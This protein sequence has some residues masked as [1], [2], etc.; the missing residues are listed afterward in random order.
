MF[1]KATA[2][3]RYQSKTDEILQVRRIDLYHNH[4]TSKS[5]IKGKEKKTTKNEIQ[6]QTQKQRQRQKQK[7]KHKQEIGLKRKKQR[8]EQ[9]KQRKVISTTKKFR[10]S[11]TKL[12]DKFEFDTKD[13]NSNTQKQLNLMQYAVFIYVHFVCDNAKFRIQFSDPSIVNG[14]ETQLFVDKVCCIGFVWVW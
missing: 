14:I 6:Q 3:E 13:F 10:L 1:E 8:R 2:K 4:G 7:I 12:S 5:K 11:L 9:E